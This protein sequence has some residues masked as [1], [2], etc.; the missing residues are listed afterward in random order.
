MGAGLAGSIARLSLKKVACS[1]VHMQAVA[2][3]LSMLCAYRNTYLLYTLHAAG[4]AESLRACVCVC[5]RARMCV[6][7]YVCVVCL[8]R[9]WEQVWSGLIAGRRGRMGERDR[10]PNPYHSLCPLSCPGHLPIANCQA[11][12]PA[13]PLLPTPGHAGANRMRCKSRC[14]SRRTCQDA[15]RSALAY[16]AFVLSVQMTGAP[17]GGDVWRAIRH[18]E[19]LCADYRACE[20]R[21]G[22]GKP[23]FAENTT[24]GGEWH[25]R[26]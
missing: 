22:L 21:W 25:G 7:T 26:P 15:C 12:K 18:R 16:T 6:R 11:A 20:C 9:N 8:F 4:T 1:Y 10:R 23:V 14:L 19:R 13:L 3:Y 17:V 24:R 5:V 2:R